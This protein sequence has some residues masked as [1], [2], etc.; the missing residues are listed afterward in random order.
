MD[1]PL[2]EGRGGIIDGV[3]IESLWCVVVFKIVAVLDFSDN[4]Q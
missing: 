3:R 2:K 4:D 1:N